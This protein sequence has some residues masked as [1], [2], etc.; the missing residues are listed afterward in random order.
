[1]FL[2]SYVFICS[3]RL[4]ICFWRIEEYWVPDATD[5]NDSELVIVNAWYAGVSLM[6]YGNLICSW[7]VIWCWFLHVNDKQ[8]SIANLFA[9]HGKLMVNIEAH[10]TGVW[11]VEVAVCLKILAFIASVI[12]Y[13]CTR[14]V[15]STCEG[16]TVYLYLVDYNSILNLFAVIT[17]HLI[18]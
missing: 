12:S 15:I 2:S 11:F 1:V 4:L 8:Y 3:W 16:T 14:V 18:L 5:M 6:L 17:K 10:V 13:L 7:H 9:I